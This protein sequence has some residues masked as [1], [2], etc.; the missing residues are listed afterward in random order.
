MPYAVNTE[1]GQVRLVDLPLEV[2]D[3]LEQE[4]DRKWHELLLSPLYTAKSATAIYR[5]ACA[6]N[7]S[8][9]KS[10]TP[11]MLLGDDSIFE[12]VPDDLP[13]VYEDGLPAGKAEEPSTS[14]S[15]GEPES[16]T[17]PQT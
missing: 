1:K 3:T 10:L 4:T 7:G 12:L 9:P 2:L 16:S 5:A 11:A 14:G 15:S 13:E 17:G 6:Q 8:E